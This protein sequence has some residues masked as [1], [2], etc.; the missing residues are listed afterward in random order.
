MKQS[1]S[2]ANDKC[3]SRSLNLL[4][5]LLSLPYKHWSCWSQL[6]TFHIQHSPATDHI[7]TTPWCLDTWQQCQHT[8]N[9]LPL[10]FT[11]VCY[12]VKGLLVLDIP[13]IIMSTYRQRG[14]WLSAW[15]G[16][17]LLNLLLHSLDCLECI[18]HLHELGNKSFSLNLLV[19]L[20]T[21]TH[22][23]VSYQLHHTS[24]LCLKNAPAL[25]QYSSKS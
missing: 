14:L 6:E 15:N 17:G 24:A 3:D 18:K 13:G 2:Q 12:T 9:S 5:I 8:H 16:L 22:T 4:I 7:L 11:V 10:K 1:H 19:P 21:N 25:K 20:L 23:T